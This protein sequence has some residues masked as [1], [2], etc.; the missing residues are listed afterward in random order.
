MIDEPPLLTLRRN[1]PRPRKDQID[2]FRGLQTGFVVD[3][4]D[5]RGALDKG[6]KPVVSEQASFCGVA[7][8]GHAGPADILA[9][10]SAIKIAQA[11]DVVVIATDGYTR[12]AVC[13][14]LML[15]MAKN[16]GVEAFVTDGC[17]R[18]LIGIREVGLPCYSTGITP[19]SPVCNGPGTVGQP[20]VLGGSAVNSGDIVLGDEDGVVVVPFAMID[21]VIERL[22]T[23]R[24]AEAEL[25]AKV[26]NGLEIPDF[27]EQIF[28]SGRVE[29]ID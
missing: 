13:G 7:V 27:I 8:T 29:E 2:A 24:A 6:I 5:G 25:L 16:K 26:Q 19:N 11:G 23:V 14:D 4:M 17:A 15:G 18:D 3:A 1:F 12:T 20:I 21:T 9:A 22:K 10:F 28:E